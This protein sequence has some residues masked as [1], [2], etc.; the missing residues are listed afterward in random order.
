MIDGTNIGIIDKELYQRLVHEAGDKT[1]R[2]RFRYKLPKHKN[3][4]ITL[5]DSGRVEVAGSLH[6]Y[7]NDG[8]HNWNDFN[9]LDLWDTIYEFCQHYQI[10]PSEAVLHNLEFGVNLVVPFNVEAFVGDLLSYKKVPFGREFIETEGTYYQCK[11]FGMYL[12][13]YDKGT[14][15]G[16][17]EN[18]FRFEVKV[19]AM[20]NLRSVG[21]RTL[22]D[23]L[24]PSK[25][26]A[27]GDLLF[28]A[29]NY[30]L[31]REQL[32]M[33]LFT[34]KEQVI[35][36]AVTYNHQWK[37]LSRNQRCQYRKEYGRIMERYLHQTGAANR[38]A[39]VETLL[40]EKWEQLMMND[41]CNDLQPIT[42]NT[43]KVRMQHL[44]IVCKR[45]DEEPAP[46]TTPQ[47][48]RHNHGTSRPVEQ[49]AP[50]PPTTAQQQQRRH[51]RKRT[52]H[53][54]EYY[55]KHNERNRRSN[56]PNNLRRS[57]QRAFD[58]TTLFDP[59]EVI[60]LK[61]EQ[62][63]LLTYFKGTPREIKGL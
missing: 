45:T 60:R 54:E 32:P 34:G 40:Y 31:I 51:K 50:P 62:V 6:T 41:V 39:I 7:W 22:E 12:K 8:A 3:L 19:T 33:A 58:E 48:S 37:N 17:K 2:G 23:L 5:H 43:E 56:P 61:P 63:Q 57:V 26:A 30:V 36:E 35:I 15:Y 47:Q 46:P 28:K 20:R 55:L 21:V 53:P 29:W 1:I 49:P 25:L 27:L 10:T 11:V 4:H 42:A 13:C 38:K 18:I 44:S 52:H 14:H 59:L 9:R 24:I 16:R